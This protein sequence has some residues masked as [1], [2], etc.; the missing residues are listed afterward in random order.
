MQEKVGVRLMK[1]IFL[2][3]PDGQFPFLVAQLLPF[4]LRLG[5]VLFG[6][7]GDVVIL[8]PKEEKLL[9]SFLLLSGS[10]LGTLTQL[11]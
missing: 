1:V 10:A 11:S 4:A 2:D 9:F 5:N 3:V 7:L 6:K 8:V